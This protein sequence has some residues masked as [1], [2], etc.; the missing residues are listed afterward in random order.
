MKDKETKTEIEEIIGGMQ[1][2]KDFKCYSSGLE[3]LCKAQYFGLESFLVCGEED[4]TACKFA[5]SLGKTFYCQCPLR[6]YLSRKLKK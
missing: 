5:L 3:D 2:P 1:C 6:K 4:P